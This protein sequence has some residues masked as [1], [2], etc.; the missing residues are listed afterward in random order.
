MTTDPHD[1]TLAT[2]FGLP[3]AIVA[4]HVSLHRALRLQAHAGAS[5]ATTLRGAYDAA[6]LRAGCAFAP[7]PRR[8]DRVAEHERRPVVCQS[9]TTCPIPA[10]YK[11]RSEAQRR[12]HPSPIGLTVRQ[13]GASSLDLTVTLWG[14]RACAAR[15]LTFAALAATGRAG[16]WDGAAAVPF[17]LET[18]VTFEGTLGEWARR[19][20]PGC[21]RLLLEFASPLQRAD[22]EL[23]HI[24]GTLAHDLVQWDLEDS[25]D[26]AGLGKPGCDALADEARRQAA[27]T[28]DGVSIDVRSLDAEDQGLRR[29]RSNHGAFR[30]SGVS[31]FVELSGDLTRAWPWLRALALRGA[32]Q[33]RS[34][35][36]GE[37]RLWE[38]LA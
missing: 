35:G 21:G 23:A 3:I 6:L 14:R 13:T 18:H 33:K 24:L 11:P 1:A 16:L 10:L 32:G 7:G 37:V 36:L 34:F 31:G 25:G 38:P 20:R 15:D 4:A 27:A 5:L 9:P 17:D 12:D 19:G 28:L 22:G 8:C 30:L 29:S 26:S 2:P